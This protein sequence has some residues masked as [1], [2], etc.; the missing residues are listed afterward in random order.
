M[1]I[2]LVFTVCLAVYLAVYGAVLIHNALKRN[3]APQNEALTEEQ[4]NWH[5]SQKW[6]N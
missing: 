2:I 6:V 3:T 4:L 5:R 1:Y